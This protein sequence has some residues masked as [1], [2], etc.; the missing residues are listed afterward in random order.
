MIISIINNI[1]HLIKSKREIINK[2]LL[3][4]HHPIYRHQHG[5]TN[6]FA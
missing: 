1:S 6:K 5:M 2:K 3:F 4:R